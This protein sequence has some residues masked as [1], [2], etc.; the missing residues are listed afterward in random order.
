MTYWMWLGAIL[1]ASLLVYLGMGVNSGVVG[2]AGHGHG[3]GHGHDE[4]GHGS[5]GH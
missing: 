2:E 4:H 5:H 1:A 3:G